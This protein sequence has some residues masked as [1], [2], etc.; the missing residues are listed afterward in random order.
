MM[1]DNIGQN[2]QH[3][4][5]LDLKYNIWMSGRGTVK[6]LTKDVCLSIKLSPYSDNNNVF[7]SVY[8]FID[9]LIN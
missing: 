2:I 1:N 8:L 5:D 4:F 7:W 3:V 6:D 9:N